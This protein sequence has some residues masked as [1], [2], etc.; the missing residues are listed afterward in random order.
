VRVL[1]LTWRAAQDPRTQLEQVVEA[2]RVPGLVV[3]G[4]E[5]GAD[6]AGAGQPGLAWPWVERLTRARGVT[7]A[8][9]SSDVTGP[10]LEV[11]LCCDLVYV[12]EGV[13]LLL[14]PVS[15]EPGPG[16]VW[17][18]GR[19]G[20]AAL[21]RGLLDGGAVDPEEALRLG[22]AQRIL[23]VG[24]AL[25]L[26][27]PVSIHALVAARDLLRADASARSKMALELAT[28]RLVVA[29]GDPAEGA[30]AF[31]ERRP[32]RFGEAGDGPVA[33][34]AAADDVCPDSVDSADSADSID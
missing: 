34:D 26:P 3:I 33:T 10:A 9:I 18:L 20:R 11:A 6:E 13:R 25:P 7:V 27:D 8:D 17:A 4:F 1:K 24:A 5:G 15:G 23:P 31:L 14:S 16:L 22:L 21:A 12:H 30:S 2:A 28:F 19:A 29:S 32:P